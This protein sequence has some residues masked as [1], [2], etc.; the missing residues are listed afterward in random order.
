MR[1]NPWLLRMA[2]A[3]LAML[4]AVLAV[5]FLRQVMMLAL[6]S[7]VAA[8]ALALML[9]ATLAWLEGLRRMARQRR[10]PLTV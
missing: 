8:A 5:P 1:R 9:A 7:S 10:R 2:I 3:M 6:P 4:V